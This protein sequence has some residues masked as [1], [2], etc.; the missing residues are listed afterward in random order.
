M[1]LRKFLLNRTVIENLGWFL[2]SLV[3]AFFVWVIAISQSDPIQQRQFSQIPV[4]IE[5]DPG[6]LVTNNPPRTVRVNVR[7]Q[8]SVLDVLTPDDIVVRADLAGKKAGTYLVELQTQIARRAI[9]DTQPTQITVTLEE[10][11]ARQVKVQS[12]ITADPPV[13][14]EH[15]APTFSKNQVLVSGAQSQVAQVATAEVQLDLSQQRS[16]LQQDI[17]LVPV[18]QNGKIVDGVT[19]DPQSVTVQVNVRQREDVKQVPVMP[20]ILVNTL[21]QGYVLTSV[22]YSPKMI[23]VS[24]SQ[25]DLATLPGTFFTAPVDLTDRTS[26][27]DVTVPVQLP[28]SNLLALSGQNV[29]VSVGISAPTANRQFDNIPVGVI[30]LQKDYRAQLSP[31][32]VTV[33]VTGPQPIVGTLKASDLQVVVD[34]NGMSAGKQTIVPVVSVVQGKIAAENMSV[35][36]AD[37][38]VEVIPQAEATTTPSNGR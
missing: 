28:N 16:A 35:L 25:A 17:K 29:T 8:S 22:S 6:F 20:N 14:F 18:D 31:D 15:E 10:V 21:P 32:R 13:G 12:M 37:I 1:V 26:N 34:L 4:R 30:G 19:V 27:F 11:Q 23:L 36:P 24:G 33:I 3:L 9:I 5:P 7:A 38:D 2:A